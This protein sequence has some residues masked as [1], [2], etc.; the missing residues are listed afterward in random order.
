[1]NEK[2]LTS[3]SKR[4]KEK[5]SK[6]VLHYL[7]IFFV[8]YLII[9]LIWL[10]KSDLLPAKTLIGAY[11]E[12]ILRSIGIQNIYTSFAIIVP[13]I[14][15][16]LAFIILKIRFSFSK[17]KKQSFNWGLAV[18][19]TVGAIIIFTGIPIIDSIWGVKSLE[20]NL[21]DGSTNYRTKVGEVKCIESTQK[22]VYLAGELVKCNFISDISLHGGSKMVIFSFK[23]ST[24]LTLDFTNGTFIAPYNLKRIQFVITGVDEN[25]QSRLFS[26]ARDYTFLDPNDYEEKQSK[27]VAYIFGL[28]AIVC[29]T[30]PSAILS[31]IKLWDRTKRKEEN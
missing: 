22:L 25:N 13:I 21:L 1:M 14:F 28:I 3:P 29:F 23:D 31:F 19:F 6:E 27:V 5:N 17:Y 4:D 26:V 7:S 20:Q 16:S 11:W 2:S 24:S 10:F 12:I 15:I 9:I 8:V 30:L 18:F